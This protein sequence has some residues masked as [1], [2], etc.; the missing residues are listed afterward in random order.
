[1]SYNVYKQTKNGRELIAEN[2]DY[3]TAEIYRETCRG[4]TCEDV[5]Q[6]AIVKSL[7]KPESLEDDRLCLSYG[8]DPHKL[9]NAIIVTVCFAAMPVIV[10][11][12]L[13]FEK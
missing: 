8:I 13:I 12:A 6:A 5:E 11:L 4:I 3:R 7:P 1:M 10:L 2:V 9:E